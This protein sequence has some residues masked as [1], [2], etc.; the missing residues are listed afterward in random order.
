MYTEEDFRCN[1]NIGFCLVWLRL[2]SVAW[3]RGLCM[4]P[5]HSIFHFSKMAAPGLTAEPSRCRIAWH[6]DGDGLC[7]ATP[8]VSVVSCLSDGGHREPGQLLPRH[9]P[10]H[11][12]QA[13]FLQVKL[14][15]M[16]GFSPFVISVS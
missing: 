9:E 10:L 14:C 8:R 3:G 15:R 5:A 12:L 13:R 16:I 2:G 11:L 6:C 7:D 1:Y 4:T